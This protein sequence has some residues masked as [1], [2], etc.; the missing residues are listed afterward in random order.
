ML[1]KLKQKKKKNYVRGKDH[2]CGLDLIM[3]R[4]TQSIAS[5]TL[6]LNCITQE[7]ASN[8]PANCNAMEYNNNYYIIK[9]IKGDVKNQPPRPSDT[10]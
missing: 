5:N 7:G 10:E 2:F 6:R 1:I 3:S 4:I 9:E 8:Q